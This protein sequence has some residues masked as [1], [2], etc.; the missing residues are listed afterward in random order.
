V[1]AAAR[2]ADR[3][4]A[5]AA[6][7]DGTAVTCDITDAAQVA[8]LADTV[9]EL[10][11][12]LRVL[13][14][15]AGGAYGL[16][17]VESADLADW[18]TMWRVNVIGTQRVTA[19]LLPQL[20][21]SHAGTIVM[22]TSTAAYGVYEGGA[23][24]TAAKHAEQA[25]TETLR[26]ELAGRPVRVVEIAPGM[27]ATEEFS[28]TRFHGDADRAARVYDGVAEP[29]TADD[30]AECVRWSVELPQHV[31]IDRLVVRPLA[32]AAQHKVIK[33]KIG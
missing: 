4:T 14:N 3:I 28:L 20:V 27:V 9:S 16:E 32:Q 1:V 8:A 2:R 19:A 25:V 29:L 33:G 23:G 26:L 15:N 12:E 5:L 10:P 6:E 17:P 21:A 18:D 22:I 7:L 11:G 30:V 13:V 31:N 24:Y